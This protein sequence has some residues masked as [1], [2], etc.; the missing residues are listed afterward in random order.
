MDRWIVARAGLK[1][2]LL[3][4]SGEPLPMELANR[5]HAA[6]PSATHIVNIYGCTEVAA[7]ATCYESQATPELQIEAL[8]RPSTSDNSAV[9]AV[10]AHHG[11]SERTLNPNSWPA[12]PGGVCFLAYREPVR[13]NSAS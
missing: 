3:V 12:E 9:Q 11:R 4:S 10:S 1:L 6:L 8:N 7:D 5:L 13:L 2:R